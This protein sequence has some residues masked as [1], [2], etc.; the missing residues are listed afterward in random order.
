MPYKVSGS[1]TAAVNIT[2]LDTDGNKLARQTAERGDY[3][4][5]GLTVSSGI[6]FSIPEDENIKGY[7]LVYFTHYGV[8]ATGGTIS[9]S[10]NYKIHTFLSSGTLNV[11]SA[12]DVEYLI[13]AGGGGGSR[14][15][16][17]DVG[18]GGG[19]GAGG[20]LQGNISI[21]ANTYS[22]VIGNG[23]AGNNSTADRASQGVNSSVF[24][25]NAIGGG[26]GGNQSKMGGVGGSG[27]GTGYYAVGF[28]RAQPTTGQGYEG[29]STVA[30]KGGAG[31]GGAGAKGADVSGG[32]GAAGGAGLASSITGSSVYYAGGGGSY[33]NTS[34]WYYIGGAGGSGIVIIRYLI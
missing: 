21:I 26:G 9:Y 13:V 2:V 24:G 12:G 1:T 27:G 3:E 6:V 7:G 31:G 18:G 10:G 30:D 11:T 20:L 28:P 5:S 19:G 23:G 8:T 16:I 25:F 4:I 14:G 32:A 33:T 34:P 17:N 29:G 15:Y 22:V